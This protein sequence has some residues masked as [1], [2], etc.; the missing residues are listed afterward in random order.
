MGKKAK[1]GKAR[2]D[3]FYKLAKETGYRS[4]AAFKL[5]Q[6]NRKFEFLQK[7]RVVVDLC[8]APGGWLQVA[9]ENTP[10]SSLVVGVDLVPIRPIPKTICLQNDITT[11]SCRQAIKKELQTWQ[12]DAVLN[13]GAPNVG[14]SWVHDAFQQAQLTLSALKLATG[15]LRKGG[16]FVTKIFRSKDYNSLL[17]VFHQL[18]KKVHATKPQAS[19]NESAE[20]FVVCE[21]Y[22]APD[23]LDSKFLDPKYV[24]KEVEEEVQM[25]INAF[26]P[27]QKQRNRE[28]YPE[29]VTSLHFVRNVSEFINNDNYLQILAS[30]S[31]LKFDD[32]AIA[33][34]SLTTD[35][36]KACCQDIRV[37][38][39]KDI[40]RLI[41]WRKQI[42][43]EREDN[44]KEEVAEE[45][46]ETDE[47]DEELKLEEMLA[48]AKE[49]ERKHLK[50]RLKKI[51]ER[52]IKLTHRMDMKLEHPD[53]IIEQVDDV[54]LFNLNKISTKKALDEVQKGDLSMMDL[55]DIIKD[56]DIY[57]PNERRKTVRKD[58]TDYDY[59]IDSDNENPQDDDDDISM[60][61]I[62]GNDDD[63]DQ[64]D[65]LDINEQVEEENPLLVPLVN[66][67]TISERV[68]DWFSKD[69][70]AGLL[71][72]DSDDN[73]DDFSEDEEIHQVKLNKE[74]VNKINQQPQ[75][76]KT[77]PGKQFDDDDDDSEE[78]NEDDDDLDKELLTKKVQKRT[79]PE[80]DA[81]GMAIAA[82]MIQS[83]KQKRE[84]FEF[85]Y[86]RYMTDDTNLPRWFLKEE[87]KYYKKNVPVTKAEVQEYKEM[88]KAVDARPIKKVAEAKARKKMRSMKKLEKVRKKAEGITDAVD[89]SEREKWMKIKDIYKKAGLLGKKK[90]ETSYVVAKRGGGTR[91]SKP[92]GPYKVVDKRLKK[93]K[94]SLKANVK[95]KEKNKKRR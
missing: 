46:V 6:L 72:K 76:S 19:R 65:Q 26:K 17:W 34:H 93:D 52:K 22:L 94:R 82:R 13:D 43:K 69:S 75:K 56:D 10:V 16:W 81:E 86:N 53:D 62:S 85:G 12:A 60:A 24:F 80:L 27:E 73:D 68:D 39:K 28:G 32:E 31:E 55:E 2:K 29:G 38:G 25:S 37:L 33:N 95:R 15:V 66:K 57:I 88:L 70:F 61:E 1:L 4:R 78:E 21:N 44:K 71:S 59:N 90:K 14:K 7:S 58:T 18:F 87:E 20:I 64:E 11:E 35:E 45:V 41:A 54:A 83:K 74:N 51:R 91:G 23:K 84:I 5:I 67:K 63:D 8:A 47:E 9:A 92:K 50:K 36:I 48:T 40:K 79:A 3:R 49:D 42:R 89:T 77:K 30:S